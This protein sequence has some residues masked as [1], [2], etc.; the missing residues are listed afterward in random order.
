MQNANKK[1]HPMDY[2]QWPNIL[3]L[4][5]KIAIVS[6]KLA[7]ASD[8]YRIMALRLEL[9]RLNDQKYDQIQYNKIMFRSGTDQ[10]KAA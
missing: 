8:S 6:L 4:N 9:G 5:D 3:A 10:K 2:R 7:E 1:P